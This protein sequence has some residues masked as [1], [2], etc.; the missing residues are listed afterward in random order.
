MWKN[1]AKISYPYLI[2]IPLFILYAYS[3]QKGSLRLYFEILNSIIISYLTYA[4]ILTF[5]G[6]VLRSKSQ[7]INKLGFVFVSTLA[8]TF[9]FSVIIGNYVGKT[10]WGAPINYKLYFEVISSFKTSLS[11]IF[12][13]SSFNLFILGLLSIIG[14]IVF[15]IKSFIYFERF[16]AYL[17]NKKSKSNNIITSILI[18]IASFCFFHYSTGLS[19]IKNE[20]FISFCSDLD[21]LERSNSMKIGID[22][23]NQTIPKIENF[24]KK[25]VIIFSVDCLRSDHLSYLGYHRKTSPFI[26]NLYHAGKIADFDVMTSTSASSFYGI[27]STLNSK[28]VGSLSYFKYSLQ[29]FLKRQGYTN[30]FI[31]SG[32]HKNYYNLKKHYGNNIDYYVEFTNQDDLLLLEALKKVKPYE[33]GSPN[34]F[35]FHFMGPHTLGKTHK[36]YQKFKPIID[37][38]SSKYI[39]GASQDFISL[40]TNNYDNGIFQSDN[41]MKLLCESLD[42]KGYLENSII[43]VVGDHGEEL[44]ERGIFGHGKSLNHN[45]I[46][47]PILFI[48]SEPEVYK[49]NNYATLIDV[50]PTIVSRLGLPIP[51]QWQGKNLMKNHSERI[52]FHEQVP[53]GYLNPILSVIHKQDSVIFKYILNANNRNEQFYNISTDINQTNNLIDDIDNLSFYKQLIIEYKENHIEN[54]DSENSKIESVDSNYINQIKKKCQFADEY[55]ISDLLKIES[56]DLDMTCHVN[57]VKDA[58]TCIFIW[59]DKFNDFSNVSIKIEKTNNGLRQLNDSKNRNY[60]SGI[61]IINKYDLEMREWVKRT[62]CH[63]SIEEQKVN[64]LS[65]NYNLIS[66]NFG[67]TKYTNKELIEI[68]KRIEIKYSK[69]MD[70]Y[71]VN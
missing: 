17:S 11:T 27:L 8:Y 43:V 59:F 24:D 71:K 57:V 67:N 31:V 28:N 37:R 14:L 62:N 64:L 34:F 21:P 5:L 36:E 58:C 44:G 56:S 50:A 19:T 2:L 20:I 22:D 42:R 41:V 40:Y 15:H 61:D 7:T 26:D 45:T 52:T 39:T 69:Y 4:A 66:I 29:D 68:A 47:I 32:A 60:K 53:S 18:L 49:E 25:N 51:Y 6:L 13:S 38:L 16:S 10:N 9:I 3:A 35:F 70:L 30:N 55:V 33:E 54:V 48:D 63:L 65:A 1:I 23:L 46:G 12:N